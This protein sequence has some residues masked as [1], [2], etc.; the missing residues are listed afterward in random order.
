VSCR[1][2]LF[3]YTKND[4]ME[5]GQMVPVLGIFLPL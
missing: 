2:S 3:S 5:Q 1:V 4:C